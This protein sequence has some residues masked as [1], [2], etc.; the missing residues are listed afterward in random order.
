MVVPL[1]EPAHAPAGDDADRADILVV[2]DLPEKLLVFETVLEDLNQN[3]VLARSGAEALRQVLRRDFA[4]ILLDVNMPDMDGFETAAL[5]RKY[6]RSAHTP[7]IFITSYADEMQTARGYSLGAVDYI[8]SPVVPEVLR[9]KVRVFVE[10]HILQKR[11]GRQAEE[12]IALAAS[13]AA[14]KVAEESTRRSTMLAGLSHALSG[15]LEVGE[16]MQTLLAHVVPAL[17]ANATVAMLDDDGR[18]ER[19]AR[20]TLVADEEP[21]GSE[22]E[23][24]ELPSAHAAM[25][26]EALAQE[27]PL[28]PREAPFADGALQMLPLVHGERVIG[29]LWVDGEITELG[30]ALLDDVVARAAIAFAA[31][32]L[33]RNLQAE[34]AERRQ[35]E[36]RLEEASRRKDEFLAMLSHE[37][38][39]PLA[40]IRNAVEVIRLVAP[41]EPKLRWAADVTDRQVRQ[42]TRLVDELLDV[43]RISQGKIVL[44]QT[45]IN[46]VSLVSQCVETHRPFVAARKLSLA[47]SLPACTVPIRGDATRLAQ[48]INNLLTNATKYTPEGGAITVEVRRE[49]SPH[50]DHAVL[51]VRD[52]GIGIEPEL[53]PRVF[54]LFEQGKRALDRTQGGLGVGLT[55]VQRLVALHGGSVS[56]TSAGAGQGAEFKVTLPCEPEAEVHVGEPAREG[57]GRLPQAAVARRI[58]VVDD[59]AD[60]AETTTLLLTLSGHQVRAAKDGPQA[61]AT[62]AEFAPEVV[63]LDIGLPLMD[64]YEVARRLREMPQ[65]R[66]SLLIALTGYGQQGDRARGKAAGFDGHLLKPVDPYALG[67][68]IDA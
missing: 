48:V 67:K 65:T 27:H 58:L 29:A 33:Y 60:V 55:L 41:P 1:I 44:Q 8:P 49:E 16:G 51:V 53:L 52:D 57:D 59:N 38:R 5:I 26:R 61:L 46:L 34:I 14:L 18:V 32:R 31:A 50:G 17:A 23:P 63:L 62:A 28:R 24:S 13:E 35:A 54:E 25:L 7:I 66:T 4:V 12:R 11:I 56:A 40:P 22:I 42:L 64:G 15:P 2:D 45:P 30:E 10:L 3:L 19:V 9:S 47:L 39:N 6:K 20:R 37:L 43:A 68:M 36:A 21:D